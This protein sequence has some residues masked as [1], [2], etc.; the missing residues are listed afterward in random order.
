[1]TLELVGAPAGPEGLPVRTYEGQVRVGA[2][3]EPVRF[4]ATFAARVTYEVERLGDTVRIT[5]RREG[6]FTQ[7]YGVSFSVDL[8]VEMLRDLIDPDA[9]S[10]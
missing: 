7:Q 6:L 8:P 1:M 9:L 10:G 2:K 5:G 3:A 4:N